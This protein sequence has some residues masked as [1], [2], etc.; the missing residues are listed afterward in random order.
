MPSARVEVGQPLPVVESQLWDVPAWTGF[1]GELESV[2]NC[3]HNRYQVTL[4][5]GWSRRDT[6]LRVRWHASRHRFTWQTLDGPDWA[7]ELTLLALGG[8]RTVVDLTLAGPRHW[9]AAAAGRCPGA[10]HRPRID[11]DRLRQRLNLLPQQVHPARLS[12]T[13]GRALQDVDGMIRLTRR[14]G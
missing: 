2:H 10:T 11:L 14:P 9:L 1:L 3:G 13:D 12:P 7:G 6:V 4:R 8:Y 5:Q